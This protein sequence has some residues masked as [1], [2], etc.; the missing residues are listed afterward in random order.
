ME[1]RRKDS[2]MDSGMWRSRSAGRKTPEVWVG[3]SGVGNLPGTQITTAPPESQ[4]GAQNL[5]E[6][7][8]DTSG[9]RTSPPSADRHTTPAAMAYQ[10]ERLRFGERA[11]SR[12]SAGAAATAFSA[13]SGVAVSTS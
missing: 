10:V 1:L 5:P 13:S 6:A 4:T 7:L 11:V 8:D 2:R 9:G 12:S 3:F